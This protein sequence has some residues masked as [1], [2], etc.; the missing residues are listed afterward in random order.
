MRLTVKQGDRT[1]NEYRFTK[2]PVY[3]GRHANSQVYLPDKAISRQHAV[4]F[5]TQDGE[6]VLE[7]LDSANKTYL[8]DEAIHKATVKTGDRIRISNYTMELSFAEDT[9]AAKSIDMEDTLTAV[10][11]GPQIIIRKPGAEPSPA[12]RFPA[13]RASDFMQAMEAICEA[14]SLDKVLL[15][16]LD[17]CAGQFNAYHVWCALR[18]EVEGPMTCHAG[19]VR[20]GQIIELSDIKLN[21]K[22]TEA[23]A[24]DQYLLFLFSRTPN[25]KNGEGISSAMIA[26][27]LSM[28]GCYGVLYIDNTPG[29][30]P[31]SLA[32]LDYLMMLAMHTAV[33]LKNF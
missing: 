15:T 25:Q 32:D 22:I 11:R 4:L 24:N 5:T 9:Q 23:L 17:T 20:T 31:Y 18:P 29:N 13:E 8:N 12:I 30:E 16:L 28:A 27:I 14:D 21:D 10:S 2:G 26:P 19:K 33:I 7:D 3:M 1:V 6:W